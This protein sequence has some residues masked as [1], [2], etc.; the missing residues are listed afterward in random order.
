M[1]LTEALPVAGE[2]L[3]PLRST[4]GLH[5]VWVE[6]IEPER[7]ARLEEVH[8]QI[9]RDL[10]MQRKRDALQAAIVKLREEYEVVL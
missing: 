1:N 10:S 8:G 4:Y 2:W 7:N 5:Y 3:G 6:S 9:Q